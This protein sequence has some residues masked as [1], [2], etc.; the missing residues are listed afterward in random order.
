[1]RGQRWVS[2]SSSNPGSQGGRRLPEEVQASSR[3]ESGLGPQ[4]LLWLL[5]EKTALNRELPIPPEAV[6]GND[7]GLGPCEGHMVP[8]GRC[9]FRG[10]GS[11]HL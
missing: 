3:K 10:A 8:R 5:L 2:S 1:M 6:D 4:G 11:A 7:V 9:P